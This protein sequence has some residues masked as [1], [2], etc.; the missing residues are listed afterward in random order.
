MPFWV[1]INFEQQPHTKRKAESEKE[2]ESSLYQRKHILGSGIIQ[3]KMSGKVKA[4]NR[5]QTQ[6]SLYGGSVATPFLYDFI[7]KQYLE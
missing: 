1:T 7:Y 4:Q 5:K 6:E 2:W 3:K